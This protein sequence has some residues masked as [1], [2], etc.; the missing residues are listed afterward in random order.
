MTGYRFAQAQIGRRLEP[1]DHPEAQRDLQITGEGPATLYPRLPA[2]SPW[3][4]EGPQ[5]PDEEP[6]GV[7]I[8]QQE[9]TG[10]PAELAAS[11]SSMVRI[12]EATESASANSKPDD[13]L[14][15]PLGGNSPTSALPA[16]DTLPAAP[17]LVSPLGSVERGSVV[18]KRRRL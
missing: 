16:E 14:A 18:L 15:R 13:D 7:A 4:G 11:L 8:D 2:S 10:T 6:L 5:V 12:D 17:L 9:C 3:S 1:G